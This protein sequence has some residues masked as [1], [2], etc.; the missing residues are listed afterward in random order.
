M[1]EGEGLEMVGTT[2]VAMMVIIVTKKETE[3]KV[4]KAL[5]GGMVQVVEI[6]VRQSLRAM[7]RQCTLL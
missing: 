4:V 7:T 5:G 1:E 2:M 6:D 3:T